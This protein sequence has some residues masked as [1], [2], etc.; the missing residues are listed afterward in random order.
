MNVHDATELAYK[1]G[2][3]KG[4]KDGAIEMKWLVKAI[5]EFDI[6]LTD[7]QTEYLLK[8]IDED[9]KEMLEDL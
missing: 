3:S 7:D 8:R 4:R 2:Y 6:A 5:V 1:N 9:T